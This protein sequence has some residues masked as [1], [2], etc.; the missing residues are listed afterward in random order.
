MESR[1]VEWSSRSPVEDGG[2]KQA[3]PTV[4]K[5]PV[6]APGCVQACC[7]LHSRLVVRY[8]SKLGS[9]CRCH[10]ECYSM[11]GSRGAFGKDP[12]LPIMKRESL[13]VL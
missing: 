4:C 13:A 7:A 12:I 2:S 9:L 8:I 10:I 5:G 3:R 11:R 6:R 1:E